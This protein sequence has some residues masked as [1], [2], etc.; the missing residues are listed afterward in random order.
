MEGVKM[1]DRK[2]MQTMVKGILLAYVITGVIL[3]LLALLLYKCGIGEQ[4]VNAGIIFA[5]VLSVFVAGF[6]VGRKMKNRRYLYGLLTGVIY[7]VLLLSVSLIV[8]REFTSAQGGFLTT[9]LLCLGGG[10]LGGMVS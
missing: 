5:Y 3:L 7:F 9:M 10:M 2:W 1:G 4:A 6:Y 8:N